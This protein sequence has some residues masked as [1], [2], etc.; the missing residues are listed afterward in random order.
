MQQTAKP[1]LQIVGYKNSG[2]TTLVSKL[3][4]AFKNQGKTTATLKHHGH[5]G[6]PEEPANVD[7]SKH[8]SA[9]A[10]AA[11]VEGDG[12]LQLSVR[13]M[14]V[15]RILDLYQYLPHDI[16]LIEGYKQLDFPK[17]VLIKEK[18]DFE[19]L[20]RLSNIKLVIVWAESWKKETA[21]PC[22]SIDEEAAYT[23]FLIKLTE[24][25]G[26]HEEKQL[27]DN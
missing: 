16:L 12:Y 22:F 20:N 26:W 13:N 21:F 24:G 18:A 2:K 6:K 23:E 8:L 3:A 10:V 25:E 11:G 17:I 5:G 19:L 4:T 15:E 7:S 1:C 27:L 9:G 14:P